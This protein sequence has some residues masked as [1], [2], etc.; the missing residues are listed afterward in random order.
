MDPD[1]N[2]TLNN[3]ARLLQMQQV[4]AGRMQDIVAELVDRAAAPVP[5]NA[6]R[7]A[8]V[9]DKSTVFDGKDG[10]A[11]QEW[12]D[13][14]NRAAVNYGWDDE[15]KRRMAV[16]SLRGAA[17]QWHD[18]VGIHVLEFEEWVQSLKRTL[19]KEL[20][21]GSWQAIIRSRRQQINETGAQYALAM[22]TLCRKR[23]T[24]MQEEDM[25]PFLIRGLFRMEHRVAMLSNPPVDLMG[26]IDEVQR[27]ESLTTECPA[28]ES[29]AD[30]A[31]AVSQTTPAGVQPK[32]SDPLIDAL[33]AKIDSLGEQV[34]SLTATA[35]PELQRNR[36]M[37][38]VD[39]PPRRCYACNGL[40]HLARDCPNGR[41]HQR[42]YPP[43]HPQ[44]S[45]MPSGNGQVGPLGQGRP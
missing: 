13:A 15:M 30:G 18:E 3:V 27:L 26:F 20:T 6:I 16:L 21:E 7:M 31:V 37:N 38:N 11:F 19:V 1:L 10:S 33:L 9:L 23:P 34:K 8:E 29:S 22:V 36:F 35:R 40:G 44:Q 39:L 5:N 25:I 45:G 12:S 28:V 32:A 17:A 2:A 42:S 24:P 4:E 14:I 43:Y 41:D